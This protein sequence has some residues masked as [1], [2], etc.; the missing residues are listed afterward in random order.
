MCLRSR[1][2]LCDYS[3]GPGGKQERQASRI[4]WLLALHEDSRLPHPHCL[5]L[6]GGW[7]ANPRVPNKPWTSQVE[8]EEYSHACGG[9][10]CTCSA[11]LPGAQSL[12]D[13]PESRGYETAAKCRSHS[14]PLASLSLAERERWLTSPG[15][16]G[17][18]QGKGICCLGEYR[19]RSLT[20][21]RT[22]DSRCLGH[23]LGMTLVTKRI[24][25]TPV[26]LS[27]GTGISNPRGTLF[28]I[29]AWGRNYLPQLGRDQYC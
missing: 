1:F 18:V 6:P 28:A 9:M 23:L 8:D 20:L 2:S 14:L 24:N 21:Q 15:V 7:E 4:G 5:F 27:Q 3:K 29:T 16:W 25:I 22:Q 12:P 11:S 10:M 13:H 19:L 26:V 17:S